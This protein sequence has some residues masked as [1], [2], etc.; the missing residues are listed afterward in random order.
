[1]AHNTPEDVGD[2]GFSGVGVAATGSGSASTTGVTTQWAAQR[3]EVRRVILALTVPLPTVIDVEICG[4]PKAVFVTPPTPESVISRLEQPS[5]T[6]PT[7]SRPG[8]VANVAVS[9][10]S[11]D[12]SVPVIAPA[13][14]ADLRTSV[15]AA[16]EVLTLRW[17]IPVENPCT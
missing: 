7:T 5:K 9:H 15:V 6:S 8:S 11:R 13:E 12:F 4:P 14:A 1:V 17:A 2:E 16:P 10:F 3:E